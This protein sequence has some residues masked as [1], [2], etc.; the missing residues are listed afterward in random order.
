M[1]RPRRRPHQLTSPH[2]PPS[3]GWRASADGTLTVL[4][5]FDPLFL[6]IAL[7]AQLPPHFLP[8]D[9]LFE[10]AAMRPWELARAGAKACADEAME[11]D[12]EAEGGTDC[13]EDIVQ[14]G[15]L[16]CVRGRLVQV[17]DATGE[18]VSL[19]LILASTADTFDGL[20]SQSTTA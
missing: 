7:L 9:E 17:C 4:T 18:P 5:P 19:V 6:L 20:T 8:I 10:A 15:R 16:G 13:E 3:P 12:G 14:L 2:L 11:Q 1:R